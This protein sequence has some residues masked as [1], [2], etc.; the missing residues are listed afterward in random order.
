[1]SVKSGQ[2]VT[3]VFTTQNPATGAAADATGTPAGTLY[4]NG[5]ADGA[6]VTVTNIT[7]GVYKAAVT[8]PSLTAGDVVSLRIAATVATVAG[9]GVVWQEVGDTK[10]VSD[11]NDLAAGAEMDLVDAPNATAV[12]AIQS[13]LATYSNVSEVVSAVNA[14]TA[15]MVGI[16]QA[17][18]GAHGNFAAVASDGTITS[19]SQTSGTYASTRALN[20]ASSWIVGNSTSIDFYLA[21]TVP[22]A[23]VLRA[24]V[25]QVEYDQPPTFYVSDD[26]MN[27]TAVGS[28]AASAADYE[29]NTYILDI[30]DAVTAGVSGE[31]YVR[32]ATSYYAPISVTVGYMAVVLE[33]AAASGGASV[34]DIIAG[35]QAEDPP[36][37]VDVTYQN[38]V[39]NTA[40]AV[41]ASILETLQGLIAGAGSGTGYYS[42][43]VDDGADPLDGV[44]VQLS[45][46][47]AG[48]HRVYEA[49]TNALGVFTLNPDPGTYYR[50]LDLAGYTFAQGVEVEVVEP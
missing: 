19:G 17:T 2:A 50:W 9:E 20:D 45:T 42:D 27:W 39:A 1:M 13:G 46:D 49:F 15:I 32:M 38:G 4:V 37:P 6:A 30:D 12:A 16:V 24:I 23:A 11:L 35:L 36:I 26:A 14:Q 10:R 3:V 7:T 29:V 31:V 5:A 34:E 43:T 40:P 25:C 8:L 18:T 48:N 28:Q 41:L 22:V 21:F 47:A 33:T 44:R